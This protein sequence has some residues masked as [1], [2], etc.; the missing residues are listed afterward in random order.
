LYEVEIS[1]F[2]APAQAVSIG[3]Y[4]HAGE[5]IQASR[6]ETASRPGYAAFVFHQ[7]TPKT[8]LLI[9]HTLP[10]GFNQ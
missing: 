5:A 2:H 3:F 7:V 4:S 8:R 9:S 10:G 1:P 6:T